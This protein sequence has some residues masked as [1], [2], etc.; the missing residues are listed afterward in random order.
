MSEIAAGTSTEF[1]GDLA[2]ALGAVV[3]LTPFTVSFAG[4]EPIDV[5]TAAIGSSWSTSPAQPTDLSAEGL[6]TRAIQSMLYDR[7]YAHRLGDR[8]THPGGPPE[9]DPVFAS[10]LAAA[11]TGR[12]R[13]DQGW[14]IRQFGANGR[15]F[16]RKGER[17][18]TALPGT[19]QSD[20]K[21]GTALQIGT[22]I[23]LHVPRESFDAQ[24]G[25]YFALGETLDELAE[26]LS[27]VRFYFNCSA[28]SA[29]ALVAALTS[30]LNRFQVPFQLKTLISPVLYD[31][32]D[33]AVLYIAARYFCITSR[34]IKLVCERM[35]FG[36]SV[37]LFAKRLWPGI[38]VA[39]D[40]GAGESF[41]LHR[42]RLAAE[43]IIDAWRDGRED[44]SA[45]VAAVAARFAAADLDLTRPYLG[46]GWVDLFAPPARPRLP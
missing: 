41:G 32:T 36:P 25:Y 21:P 35:A 24:P 28:E 9:E 11:N 26:Q 30:A 6:L 34:I 22:S 13:W 1:E 3:I 2:A 7:A 4:G 19:Y 10:R 31:R 40:P 29:V 15:I 12:E 5:G 23:S 17:E 39:V 16:V 38:A 44:V 37:P 43:G 45:R 46:P 8:R 20:G 14:V 33:S 42:C 27:L 18:R